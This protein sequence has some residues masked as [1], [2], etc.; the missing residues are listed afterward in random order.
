MKGANFELVEDETTD[1]WLVIRDVGPWNEH[2]TVTNDA[3]NVVE[4]LVNENTLAKGMRLA[5][6][7]S[8]GCLGEIV[9]RDGK[10]ASFA[11]LLSWE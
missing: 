11:P 3:E 7:D 9:L 4:R 10:F 5:Y 2:P 6:Y 1:E 8:E